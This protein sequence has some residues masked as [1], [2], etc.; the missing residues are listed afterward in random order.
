MPKANIKAV[1]NFYF[2]ISIFNENNELFS[3]YIIK[4]NILFN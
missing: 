1:Y 3:I 2:K 4:I